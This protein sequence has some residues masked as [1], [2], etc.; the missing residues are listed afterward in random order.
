MNVLHLCIALAI[1]SNPLT[2]NRT[3][4]MAQKTAIAWTD[5]T[6]NVAWG[7]TKVSQGCKNCYAESLSK[8]YGHAVF[9][10]TAERRTFGA[11]HWQDPLKWNAD[12][13]HGIRG[14][15]SNQLVFTSSMCDVFE[16]HPQII[17][18][19]PLLWETI[20]RTP[21]LDWQIVTKRP[22]RIAQ[23]LPDDWCA[24]YANVWLGT[25]IENMDVAH[26]ADEL[27]AVPSVVRFISYEPALGPL[28]DLDL[29]GLHWIIYGGES[30]KGYRPHDLDWPRM[31]ELKCEEAG[32]AFFFK[33]SPAYRTELGTLLDGRS[34]KQFPIPG[35]G[36]LQI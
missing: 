36:V 16:D 7:C 1:L 20:R 21:C 25:S 14:V 32:I 17:G 33:Q 2:T 5:H 26:R 29:N 23:S 35:G 19:L 24:G 9:G 6:F 27:R 11:K 28:D 10:P 22:E 30:G 4:T 15:G 31:M 13:A 34:V 12:K 3:K 8:R 18:Q